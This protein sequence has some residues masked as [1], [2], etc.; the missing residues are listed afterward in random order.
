MKP[1]MTML[2]LLNPSSCVFSLLSTPRRNKSSKR[3]RKKG[4]KPERKQIE[5]DDE[6]EDE[7]G[8]EDEELES[9]KDF[10]DI[11]VK[12][13]SLRMDVV[14]KAGLNLARNKVEAAFYESKIRVNGQ[15]ILK[16]SSQ[17]YEG[18]EVDVE[19]GEPTTN[20]KFT[21]VSRVEVKRAGDYNPGEGKL[22][23]IL[24]R[25]PKLM[26]ERPKDFTTRRQRD[27]EE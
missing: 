11:K 3:D 21:Y 23:V 12:L 25:Y 22:V 13:P 2:I 18:D 1:L 5:A 20:P 4:P 19:L 6:Y 10:K 7:D 8:L 15:K 26:V 16:K 14:L 17:V 24:R 9:S 27:D